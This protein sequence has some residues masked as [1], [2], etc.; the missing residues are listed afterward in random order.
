MYASTSTWWSFMLTAMHTL[1]TSVVF[2]LCSNLCLNLANFAKTGFNW[3]LLHFILLSIKVI[4]FQLRT[5]LV[6]PHSPHSCVCMYIYFFVSLCVCRI[7]CNRICMMHMIQ[8][9]KCRACALWAATHFAQQA[10][11]NLRLCERQSPK[12]LV[13]PYEP[14]EPYEPSNRRSQARQCNQATWSASRAI[15]N[16]E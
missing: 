15:H 16:I 7:A 14:Y 5:K 10:R 13:V 1:T 3:F 4:K 9:N 6:S 8:A 12:W 2:L 11:R